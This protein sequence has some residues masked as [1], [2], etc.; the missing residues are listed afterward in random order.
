MAGTY[1]E[2]K[3][4][5]IAAIYG[6]R[7]VREKGE[8][9]EQ[10]KK[11]TRVTRGHKHSALDGLGPFGNC[12]ECGTWIWSTSVRVQPDHPPCSR[13][14]FASLTGP[15]RFLL[16]SLL[17]T[18]K[19][20]LQV[21]DAFPHAPVPIGAERVRDHHHIS[22]SYIMLLTDGRIALSSLTSVPSSLHPFLSSIIQ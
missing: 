16:F 15:S 5:L 6:P 8:R 17:V 7:R 14:T 22:A 13:S 21:P 11:S 18:F 4:K 3:K 10:T 12:S 1:T 19:S 2:A 9:G 20:K